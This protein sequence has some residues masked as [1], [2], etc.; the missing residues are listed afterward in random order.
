MR[1]IFG[2]RVV[3]GCDILADELACHYRV[4][5]MRL[6]LRTR[7]MF[8][9]KPVV[10]ARAAGTNNDIAVWLYEKATLKVFIMVCE[11]LRDR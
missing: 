2:L 5:H 8:Q 3:Y 1:A 7:A 4:P 11:L 10:R 9:A 6:V